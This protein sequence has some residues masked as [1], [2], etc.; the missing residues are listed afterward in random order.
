MGP[1][2]LS[3]EFSYV[4]LICRGLF[5]GTSSTFGL[6]ESKRREQRTDG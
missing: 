2:E 1:P 5:M 6:L 4:Y 3:S